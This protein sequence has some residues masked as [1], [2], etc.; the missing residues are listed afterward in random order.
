MTVDRN[1]MGEVVVGNTSQ[2]ATRYSLT[3]SIYPFP[4]TYGKLKPG[5]EFFFGCYNKNMC[6]VLSNESPR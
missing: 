6:E 1:V 2:S 4:S 5:F 3:S